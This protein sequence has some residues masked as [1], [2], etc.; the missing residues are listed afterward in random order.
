MF[1]RKL[2]EDELHPP[3]DAPEGRIVD[4]AGPRAWTEGVYEEGGQVSSEPLSDN[5]GV[6]VFTGHRATAVLELNRETYE[7]TMPPRR[8]L[9]EQIE[10]GRRR[11]HDLMRRAR[12]FGYYRQVKVVDSPKR[13]SCSGPGRDPVIHLAMTVSPQ[14][15]R[16]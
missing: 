5:F 3:S 9:A 8:S 13:P 14:M 7:Q 4:S 1:A 2:T 12:R 11:D 16:A 6:R 15:P 10:D